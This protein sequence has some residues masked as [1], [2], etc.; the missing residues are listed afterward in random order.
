MSSDESYVS[1]TW[2]P[3][4]VGATGTTAGLAVYFLGVGGESISKNVLLSIGV[5][6]SLAGSYCSSRLLAV[7]VQRLHV[8]RRAGAIAAELTIRLG[9]DLPLPVEAVGFDDVRASAL[10]PVRRGGR[11]D[12]DDRKGGA[13]A[14][15]DKVIS[16]RAG[17]S[18]PRKFPDDAVR[19]AVG[20]APVIEDGAVGRGY[21]NG[22]GDLRRNVR[23]SRP[24]G[25][26]LAGGARAGAGCKQR[27]VGAQQ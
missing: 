17:Y 5:S 21:Q 20:I 7:G 10:I 19:L 14:L 4:V 18:R 12:L 8:E 9:F 16:R 11:E 26:N 24:I 13:E 1:K 25:G 23:S 15:N 3:L 2:I 27:A 6:L 22:G